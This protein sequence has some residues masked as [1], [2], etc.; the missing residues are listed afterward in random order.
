MATAARPV[1]A[2]RHAAL[3]PLAFQFALSFGST[4]SIR[5]AAFREV[6]GIGTE[7]ELEAVAEGGENRFQHQLPKAARHTPL[8]LKRGIA[9][10]GSALVDWCRRT[11]ENGFAQKIELKVVQVFLLDIGGDPVRGWS[12]ENAYPVKWSFE[13][14]DSTK[15]QVALETIEF[16][17]GRLTKLG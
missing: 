6:S 5:E 2:P 13:G 10:N 17:Y 16:A 7:I 11:L 8:V 3:L 4:T 1:Q 12:F 9:P 15:N 14:F